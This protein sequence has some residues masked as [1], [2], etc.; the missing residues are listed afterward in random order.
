M[1]TRIWLIGFLLFGNLLSLS[2]LADQCAA[3]FTDG[4]TNSSS[5]GSIKFT[6]YA[7]L[8][9]NPDTV[10][11]TTD[12]KNNG[13]ATTCTS[14]N[15]SA[16][17]STVPA[18]TGF[19]ENYTSNSSH[20][21][22]GYSAIVNT[23]DYKDLTVKNGGIL[24]F[25]SSWTTYKLRKL[26]VES[27]ST[28]Y[29]TPG[30]YYIDDLEIKGGSTLNVSGSGTVRIYARSKA[31]FKDSSVINGG[32]NGDA[33]KLFLYYHA[34]G[35]D[36]KIKV[37]SGAR[38]TAFM[39]SANKVEVKGTSD[40]YGAISAAGEIHIKNDSWVTY[41][42]TAIANTD[43][44]SSCSNGPATVDHFLITHDG[45][46]S[47]CAAETVTIKA[48]LDAACTSL[49]T[50]SLSM[51]FQADG[52][53]KSSQTF[54]GTTTFN[55]EHTTAETLTLSLANI[56]V[57]PTNGT[58][59]SNGSGSSCDIV[60]NSSGCSSGNTCATT[61][62]DA[63]TNSA[64]GGSI[65]FEDWG[66]LISNPDTVLQSP[67]VIHNNSIMSTCGT[68]DCTA[69]G[70]I[71][72]ALSG[73]FET[74]TSSQN[75]EVNGTT[76]TITGNDYQD[77]VVKNG[78][79]FYMSSSYSTYRF[80]KLTL[81]F[82]SRV[83]LTPGDY[84][85]DELEVKGGSWLNVTGTGTV[86][87]FVKTKAIFKEL[88]LINNGLFGDASKLFLYF[89]NGGDKV[90]I[91][92]AA[93]MAGFVYSKGGVE[94]NNYG[95]I[96][97]GVSA[98]GQILVKD[99]SV[100]SYRGSSLDSTDFGDAC[101]SSGTGV[102]HYRFEYD[103]NGLTCEAEPITIKACAN[104]D[105]ST[106]YSS[107]STITLQATTPA[108][109][110][111]N[112]TFTFTGST[113]VSLGETASTTVTLGMSSASPS[114]NLSCYQSGQLDGAC[115]Y[116]TKDTGFI[117]LNES[118]N[119]QTV[120]LQISGKPSNVGYNAKTLTIQAVQT[121]TN[122]GS[123]S[124]LFADG[125]N[126][127]IDFAYQ[128][129]DPGTCSA[130]ALQVLNNNNTYSL[131]TNGSYTA[132]NILFS[133]GSKATIALNYPDAGKI[134]L[135][136]KKDIT[137]E[138]GK[139]TTMSGSSNSFIV[140]PFGYYMNFSG[141]PQATDHTGSVFRR[142]G[143]KFDMTLSAV[144]WQTG[145][146]ANGDGHPDSSDDLSNNGVTP[147]FGQETQTEFVTVTTGIVSPVSG[148]NPALVNNRFT[149]F[150]GGSQSKTGGDGLSWGDVGVVSFTAAGDG[151]YLDSGENVTTTIP[152]VGRFAPSHFR[153]KTSSL[154][155]ACSN[156]S[157]MGQSVQLAVNIEA[158]G[159]GDIPLANY[160]TGGH[161][162]GSISY[163]AE[164]NDSG[165]DIINRLS[166]MSASW[167]DGKLNTTYQPTFA[168][169]SAT[170]WID[171]PFDNTFIG[172]KVD[173]GE[174]TLAL[175]I[176]DAVNGNANMNA[177]DT[178][179]CVSKGNCD[180]LKLHST[181]AKFRY[182]RLNS[183]PAFG[184]AGSDLPLPIYTEYWD[185]NGFVLSTDDNCSG[186]NADEIKISGVA[187]SPFANSY[188]V[189]HMTDSFAIGTTSVSLTPSNT[190]SNSM[191]AVGGEFA[192]I[193]TAPNFTQ[194]ANGYLPVEINLS[195]YPWLQFAW[196]ANGKGV[197]ETTL[198]VQNATFGVYR[199]ND[200][201]ISWREK[202]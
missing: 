51:D 30:T 167:T 56:S 36:D 182:G 142:A 166:A 130:N 47:T 196:S 43:F 92:S 96:Y 174:A 29:M 105:C 71:V 153:V 16:S 25:S 10:L 132:H 9:N 103:G 31:K 120:P 192:L 135:L 68:A 159:V 177:A 8:I 57:T 193:L 201:V 114:A 15:C 123:C 70:N 126:V 91:E 109:S 171:G 165:V 50:D 144:Q 140:R 94:A 79:Q 106:L 185:S 58:K 190:D 151:N 54:V 150:S 5:S 134:K 172:I 26:K 200:R 197:G 81:E 42:D 1:Y 75:L 95:S 158:Q 121:D 23:G 85:I 148:N 90:L 84:Y 65:T 11:N 170:P 18:L 146:D 160:D 115:D 82:L 152:Y 131:A 93:T 156:F 129:E 139:V 35:G 155:Q 183:T 63:A 99:A 38:V 164:D 137:L 20:T 66:R 141:N 46:G 162:L 88:S 180:A 104:A 97:G 69:D 143:E 154:T 147:N 2:A 184:P 119:N 87:L 145:E 89:H 55:F 107:P 24:Y 39:Y 52:N 48:C 7:R 124:A 12:V 60:F 62:A 28:V 14:A 176:K 149:T 117:I 157:Y 40:V 118:D 128:C 27:Y 178:G 83:Y 37:E 191:S 110:S 100:I 188:N 22:N 125:A 6:N 21:I 101:S 173:D 202:R 116:T 108:P 112:S 169:L 80:K 53:T 4:L 73:K 17:G 45:S 181:A 86:R 113:S 76:S 19:F 194:G 186:L 102:N 179:D 98:E 59:C 74:N 111:A 3:T 13:F 161:G 122:T 133:S 78:A 195:T 199:G 34:T 41:R 175:P 189:I 127:A 136:A 67:S 138:P 72:P 61:F 33:S 64:V 187:A 168:R 44:G 163:V 198:P 32:S 77:V 49:S